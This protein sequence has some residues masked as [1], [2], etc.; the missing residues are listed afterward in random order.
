MSARKD[1]NPP[2]SEGDRVFE[3][4]LL[5]RDD[6]GFAQR[7]EHEQLLIF[8]EKLKQSVARALKA[9]GIIQ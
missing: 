9:R 1:P 7:P 8:G 4:W 6:P 5:H 3:Y 2:Q